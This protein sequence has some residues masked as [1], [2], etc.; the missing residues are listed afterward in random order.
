M[1]TSSFSFVSSTVSAPATTST[2]LPV[3]SSTLY[4]VLEQ[5][6]AT[7]SSFVDFLEKWQTLAGAFLGVLLPILVGVVSFRIR[8]YLKERTELKENI[9]RIEVSTVRSLDDIGLIKRQLKL[10]IKQILKLAVDTENIHTPSGV[11]L[12]RV[13]FPLTGEIYRDHDSPML[14]LK[15]FYLH[16]KL[17]I[18]DNRLKALNTVFVNLREDFEK[19]IQQNQFQISLKDI[20]PPDQ[21]KMYAQNLRNFLDAL[22]KV[23]EKEI[24]ALVKHLMQINVFNRKL[25]VSVLNRVN[26]TNSP[27]KALKSIQSLDDV[28]ASIA[29]DVDLALSNFNSR[30]TELEAGEI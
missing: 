1:T 23:N 4:E 29:A 27:N 7:S 19:L 18:L 13:N 30:I 17:I 25:K 14:K 16:N 6:C 20:A 12:D 2:F 26:V 11:V 3:S 22:D 5:S 10:T 21:R 15:N 8:S 9:R 24:P 28:D